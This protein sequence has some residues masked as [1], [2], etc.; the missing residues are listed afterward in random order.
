[1]II[2]HDLIIFSGEEEEEMDVGE[3][4]ELCDEG[5]PGNLE[6]EGVAGNVKVGSPGHSNSPVLYW[7]DHKN[8]PIANLSLT[9][10]EGIPYSR[11]A[12]VFRGTYGY[13]FS[14]PADA[15]KSKQR[16]RAPCKALVLFV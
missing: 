4:G 10:P 6:M 2:D 12:R 1:M 9:I 11:W 14:M 15:V 7:A 13:V 3:K 5:N 8:I 16:G